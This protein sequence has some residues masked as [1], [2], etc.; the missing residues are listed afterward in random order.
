MWDK[1]GGNSFMTGV[2]HRAGYAHMSRTPDLTSSWVT[3]FFSLCCVP[4]LV[5]SIDF[6][7]CPFLVSVICG[8]VVHVPFPL[9]NHKM[10]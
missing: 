1:R 3:L 6:K 9:G 7:F 5:L 2:A 10:P 8:L 4:C